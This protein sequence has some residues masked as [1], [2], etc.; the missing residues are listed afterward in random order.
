MRG[1]PAVSDRVTPGPSWPVRCVFGLALA[2]Y[3]AVAVWL[4]WRTSVLE[5][6]SDMFDWIERWNRFQASGDLGRYLWAPHNFHHLVWTFSVLGLD[7]WLFGGQGRLFL[8]VGGGCMIATA[9]M[10]A[11]LGGQA[12]GPKMR[13][14]GAG[15]PLAIGLM[16]CDVLDAS[17]HINTTYF[18]ALV[19][20]VAAIIL[21]GAPDERPWARRGASLVCAAAAGLGNGVGLAVWPALVFGAWRSGRKGWTLAVLAAGVACSALYLVGEASGDGLSTVGHGGVSPTAA[22]TLGVTYLGLPW[23]RAA[24]ALGG[25]VGLAVLMVSLG[26][27]IFRGGPKSPAADQTAV[28]LIVFSLVTAA[29]AGLARTGDMTPAQIPFRYTVLLM[30]LHVGLWVLALPYVRQFWARRPR[31]ANPSLLAAALILLGHQAV[32][33][34]YAVR[35]GDTTLRVVADFR[36]GR[37]TPAMT[38]MIHP[39]MARAERI[40]AA[41][42]ARGFYQSEL[43]PDPPRGPGAPGT[44]ASSPGP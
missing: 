35:T 4:I 1:S 19:F 32:M 30:P 20:A 36:E 44:S 28:A 16:G 41:L 27:S 29:M 39:D 31:L 5:P 38:P 7:L 33:A 43:R 11:R 25:L 34:L 12:A 10:L 24:P 8:A 13:L 6:F 9:V 22:L 40:S 42:Q 17:I 3:A 18:H 26:A 21:A 2:V 23:M 37:R 14:V 15:I